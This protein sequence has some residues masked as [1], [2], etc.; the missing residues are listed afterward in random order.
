MDATETVDVAGLVE[1]GL[2]NLDAV[3]YRADWQQVDGIAAYTACVYG[4]DGDKPGELQ[5]VL[6][7]ATEYGIVAY[8]WAEEDGS[9][10]HGRGPITL[11][12]DEAVEA[13]EEYAS[14]NDEEPD[15]DDIIR[16]VVESGYFGDADADD[17]K[18]ICEEA[19]KYS[20]GYLLLPAGAFCGHPI[21]RL[22]TTSGYL[23]C[24]KYIMLDA[25]HPRLAYAADALLRAVTTEDEE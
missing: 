8:R 13:G 15:A 5:I 2:L 16:Q 4:K 22:W 24:E 3:F 19:T 14:E 6:E 23:Q 17:I 7:S 18:A 10:T 11:D 21:G 12:R 1:A 20:Q 25:T 9:G